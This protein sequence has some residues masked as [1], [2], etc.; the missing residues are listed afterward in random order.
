MNAPA[1]NDAR[2][3]ANR[4]ALVRSPERL[5]MSDHRR[6]LDWPV[7]TGIVGVFVVARKNPNGSGL[8]DVCP[9]GP[10]AHWTFFR[11]DFEGDGVGK[12]LSIDADSHLA[13]FNRVALSGGDRFDQSRVLIRTLQAT[14]TITA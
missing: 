5:C 1:S 7:V 6:E 14:W 4:L 8:H 3:G 2:G 9:I 10:A 12:Q 11:V 13:D